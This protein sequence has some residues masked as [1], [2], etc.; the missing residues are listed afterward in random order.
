MPIA[1]RLCETLQHR[2]GQAHPL[3]PP[4]LTRELDEAA[5]LV[6]AVRPA[7]WPG[8]A[9][10]PTLAFAPFPTGDP[11]RAGGSRRRR[12]EGFGVPAEDERASRRQHTGRT[13]L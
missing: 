9:D 4:T 5:W 11:D 1:V 12:E 8:E 2:Q 3:G 13:P 7:P 6:P 10:E